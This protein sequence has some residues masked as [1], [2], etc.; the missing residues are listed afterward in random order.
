MADIDAGAFLPNS[1]ADDEPFSDEDSVSDGAAEDADLEL[2]PEIDVDEEEEPEIQI[3]D[4]DLIDAL[5]AV[6]NIE[7]LVDEGDEPEEAAG[8]APPLVVP[9]LQNLGPAP[10]PGKYRKR[11]SKTKLQAIIKVS[12][13]KSSKRAVLKRLSIDKKTFKEWQKK[14][15]ELKKIA[16]DVIARRSKSSFSIAHAGAINQQK[17]A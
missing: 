10:A 1:A 13:G 5:D 4:E 9:Q 16:R 17:G 11:D 7:P 15:D 6:Q 8:P 2:D 12:S 3:E 14:G